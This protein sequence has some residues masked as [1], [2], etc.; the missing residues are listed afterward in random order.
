[1]CSSA[2]YDEMYKYLKEKIVSRS[3]VE[4]MLKER[5][6]NLHN[7]VETLWM[8]RQYKEMNSKLT[9]LSKVANA[10][11]INA[12]VLRT[13]ILQLVKLHLDEIVASSRRSS[14]SNVTYIV[15]DLI[16]LKAI[17][18]ELPEADSLVST[19]LKDLV[20]F[21]TGILKIETHKLGTHLLE[22]GRIGSELVSEF[23]EFKAVIHQAF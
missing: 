13:K 11:I 12:D 23:S 3:E 22:K 18:D 9:T 15:D 4:K 2:D 21:H 16:N 8:K 7:E 1:M 10:K 5:V 14:I 19:A 17:S 6:A 20:R